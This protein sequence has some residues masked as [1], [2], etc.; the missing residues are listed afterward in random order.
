MGRKPRPGIQGQESRRGCLGLWGPG[1]AGTVRR[2]SHLEEGEGQNE[3][4]WLFWLHMTTIQLLGVLASLHP[5]AASQCSPLAFSFPPFC[6]WALLSLTASA[7]LQLWI[8]MTPSSLSALIASFSL[9]F[10]LLLCWNLCY[11][12]LR[13]SIYALETLRQGI[14]QFNH[15]Q[16]QGTGLYNLSAGTEGRACFKIAKSRTY[17]LQT[18]KTNLAPWLSTIQYFGSNTHSTKGSYIHRIES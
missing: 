16:P 2:W 18:I 6:A 12:A 3:L 7:S 1:R 14:V 13:E 11:P 15:L 5:I 8:A 4:E 9:E 17:L 10:H